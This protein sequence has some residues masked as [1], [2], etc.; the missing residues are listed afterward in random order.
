[1]LM[2]VRDSSIRIFI[3]FIFPFGYLGLV[4]ANKTVKVFSQPRLVRL[5]AAASGAEFLDRSAGF[6]R[7]LRNAANPL[8]LLAFGI[9]KIAIREL[10]PFL[11][12]LA[13]GYVP[14]AFV[15]QSCHNF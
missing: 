11:F 7:A 2:T 14:V 1:M 13:L 12:R 6:T 10:G 4:A 9:W 8:F 15:F 3:F 5:I